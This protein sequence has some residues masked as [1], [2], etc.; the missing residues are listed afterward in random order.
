[1]AR[2]RAVCV[3]NPLE[4]HWSQMPEKQF[5][6][7]ATQLYSVYSYPNVILPLLGG[8]LADRFGLV[9]AN[10]IYAGLV[11]AGQGLFAVGL[12]LAQ[13]RA[14][15][16]V[17]LTGRTVFGLGGES[18]SVTMSALVARWFSGRELALALGTNLA[19]ARLG[20]VV[21][22]I[23]SLA[24]AQKYGVAWA[25]WAGLMFCALSFLCA[26]GV[27]VLDVAVDRIIANNER[28]MAEGT[29][30]ISGD[31]LLVSPVPSFRRERE[32]L[33]VRHAEAGS[34]AVKMAAAKKEAGKDGATV[35]SSASTP[36]S[37]AAA[38]SSDRVDLMQVFK[39]PLVLWL[40]TLSCLT[41]YAAI[42]PF[43]SVAS[44]FI[45]RR[46]DTSDQT[47]NLTMTI[48]FGISAVLSPIL[49][50]VI[51]RVGQRATLAVVA[52]SVVM[53][54]HLYMALTLWTPI[55]AL[56]LLGVAYS[57]YAAALWPS[58]ALVVPELYHGTAYGLVTAVQNL[59]LALTP[60]LVSAM[61]ADCP[62]HYSCVSVAF[63][64]IGGVGTFSG[65]ALWIVNAR[66]VPSILNLSQADIAALS[67]DKPEEDEDDAKDPKTDKRA[68]ARAEAFDRA[69]LDQP[70]LE[71]T[72]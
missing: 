58:I 57:V 7:L 28:R 15:W 5:D 32:V 51:D 12:S 63:A 10:T 21:N 60:I 35:N 70:L 69:A 3:Q 4:A 25:G 36:A 23:V 11:T 71:P 68:G 41:V 19:V 9:M 46:Y 56:V 13:E 2:R 24:L 34:D 49:G 20:S 54:A 26:A 65:V 1:L 17:M 66:A 48:L 22:D 72:F 8:F 29:L 50:G 37:D 67:A 14:S 47:A 59:G 62:E 43:N 40:L 27:H 52:S 33:T 44:A 42:L 18:L 38:A 6:F 39:F 45:K 31:D 61:M 30:V 64:I 16:A 53:L 55:V